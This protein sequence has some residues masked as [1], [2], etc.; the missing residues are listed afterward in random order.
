MMLTTITPNDLRIRDAVTQELA[1]DSRVDASAVG[2]TAQQGVVT[3]TGFVDSYAG[4][5]AAERAAKRVRG[6][7]AVAND[8]QVRLRI[9][10]T[11]ADIAHDAA[12]ALDLRAHVPDAVQV[13]VHGGHL[14]LTGTVPTLFDRVVAEKAVRHLPGM[15]GLV[16]RIVVVAPAS[17]AHVRKE[18]IRALHRDAAVHADGIEVTVA[19][20][21][22]VLTGAVATWAERESAEAAASHAPGIAAV[23]N[24]LA[25]VDAATG[26]HPDEIC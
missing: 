13:V 7:R 17:P 11:D 26:N 18:I 3:L 10:R 22:V 15:K 19:D 6:V 23:D 9:E 1:W 21:T 2:V 4:K 25:V 5:L 16:N 14:T 20:G 24:R 8:I 12:R